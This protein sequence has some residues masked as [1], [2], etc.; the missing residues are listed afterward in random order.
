MLSVRM[1][2][3]R[4]QDVCAR[5][6]STEVIE[7]LDSG[8]RDGTRIEFVGSDEEAFSSPALH[9]TLVHLGVI[10]N[11]GNAGYRVRMTSTRAQQPACI[12][13]SY[14]DL[15]SG[16]DGLFVTNGFGSSACG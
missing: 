7:A 4:L 6:L 12:P 10:A 15:E 2:A 9:E 16:E 3:S 1:A 14:V 8:L 13:G 11:D 5:P